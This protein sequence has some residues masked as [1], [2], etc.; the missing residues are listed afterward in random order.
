[1]N[2]VS[3]TPGEC[4]RKDKGS[5]GKYEEDKQAVWFTKK[6]KIDVA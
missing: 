2:S 4:Y 5:M 1:M 3:K 6:R